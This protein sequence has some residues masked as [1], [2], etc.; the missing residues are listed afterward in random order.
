M[1]VSIHTYVLLARL[2]K[3][4]TLF[5]HAAALYTYYR[6]LSQEEAI[7]RKGG[8]DERKKARRR[9]ERLVRVSMHGISVLGKGSL[10]MPQRNDKNSLHT[11]A[12]LNQNLPI[13][14]FRA[15]SLHIT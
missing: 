9:R 5:K 11:M 4:I 8:L 12:K 14:L 3:C 7:K 6:T 15:L 2:I 13:V 10:L 1:H